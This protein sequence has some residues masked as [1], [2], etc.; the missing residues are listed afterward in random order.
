MALRAVV[1]DYGIVLTGPANAEAHAALVRLTGLTAEHFEKLYW[2]DRPAYDQGVLNGVSYWQKFF[3]AAGLPFDSAIIEQLNGWDARL[4]GD[5]NEVMVAWHEQLKQ[6]GL[7]SAVLSNMGDVICTHILREHDS[8]IQRFDALVWSYQVNLVKPDP[9]IF[10][11]LLEKLA[12]R[13][14]ETLFIDD[15]M[16]NIVAARALGMQALLFTSV[17]QLRADLIAAGLDRNLPLPE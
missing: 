2:T 12:V 9:A 17:P 10:Q 1:F 13:P 8:W 11:H 3:R 15:K 4:W 14:E 7:R 6:R 5:K 16:P